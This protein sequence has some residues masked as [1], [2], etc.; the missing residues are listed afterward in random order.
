MVAK[1]M[2]EDTYNPL[3]EKS[4]RWFQTAEIQRLINSKRYEFR[5]ERFGFCKDHVI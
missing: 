2:F 3:N 5:I 4:E 1:N